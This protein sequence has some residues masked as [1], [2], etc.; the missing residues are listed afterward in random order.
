M[1]DNEII[2]ALREKPSRDN[3]ALL[4]E[5]ADHLQLAVD[6]IIVLTEERMRQDD[7]IERLKEILNAYALQYGTVR[8]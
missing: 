5:A 2:K 8:G 4:D 1:T 7:E 6:T 3:R